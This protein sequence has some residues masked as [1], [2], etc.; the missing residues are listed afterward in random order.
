MDKQEKVTQ[1]AGAE[2]PAISF[3]S[4]AKPTQ[5]IYCS[6][7]YGKKRLTRPTLATTVRFAIAQHTLHLFPPDCA[8]L[9]PGYIAPRR[10]RL[11]KTIMQKKRP[12]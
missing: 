2:P 5:H 3:S 8:A 4:S 9:H 6:A 7:G 10:G 1:G 12:A 11:D